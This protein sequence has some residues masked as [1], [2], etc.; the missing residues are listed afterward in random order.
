[1]YVPRNFGVLTDKL[2]IPDV[3]RE[4]PLVSWQILPLPSTT[5]SIYPGLYLLYRTLSVLVL[6]ATIAVPSVAVMRG[7]ARFRI[8][9]VTNQ[10]PWI[11]YIAELGFVRHNGNVNTCACALHIILPVLNTVQELI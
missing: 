3:S 4:C 2:A 1:M 6:A 5:R 8:C 9:G 7:I 11:L 10:T